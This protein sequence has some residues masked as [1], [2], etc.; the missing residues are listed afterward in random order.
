MTYYAYLCVCCDARW[1]EG[2]GSLEIAMCEKCLRSYHQK[3]STEQ[4]AKY[5]CRAEREAVF[6]VYK[7]MLERSQIRMGTRL[8]VF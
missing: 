5:E 7:R 3:A 6:S 1:G 2:G 4:M 8:G